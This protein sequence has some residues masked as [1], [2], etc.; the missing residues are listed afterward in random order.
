EQ[1]D[2]LLI[3]KLES[4]NLFKAMMEQ[5]NR[6]VVSTLMKGQIPISEADEV[7]EAPI[8]RR[9]HDRSQYREEKMDASNHPGEHQEGHKAPQPIRHAPKVGRNEPCPCGSGKKF[10]NCHGH[11]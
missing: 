4:F 11:E 9:A 3:Y 6:G 5:I 7:K 10:K 1:K 2:P 8:A